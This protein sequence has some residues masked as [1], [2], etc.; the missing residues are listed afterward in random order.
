MDP[1]FF[2]GKRVTVTGGRGFLGRF[3]C[4]QLTASGAQVSALGRRDYDL[5]EQADVRRLFAE[6]RPQVLIHLAAA[7]GGIG[8]NV[9][10]PGR[11]LYENGLM[12]LMLLDEARR[13]GVEKFVLI[14]STCSYPKEA[15]MPLREESIWEGKPVGATG[16]YGMAKR[17][18]HE[19]LATYR[20]QYGLQGVV[21]V[22][23]NLYGPEDHFDPALSHVIPGIIRRYVEAVEQ[24]AERVQNWGSG[25]PTRE[26]LHVRDAAR[27]IVLATARH[28][29]PAPVNLGTGVE[30]PIRELAEM[31]ARATGFTGEIA[32]DPT[33]PDG[34]PRRVLDVS[35]ARAFGF[36]ARVPL[37]E[38]LA[39]TV[40]WYKA[41]R[42]D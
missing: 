29:D 21:L 28:R 7:V 35:K 10:N 11:F 41:H 38:G 12:G 4:R 18:L 1:A 13:A 25:T 20:E 23:A 34:Q 39:E 6:Q 30:T 32:W 5:I 15:P 33:Q 2:A 37:A 14:S 42:P 16:P 40:A 27:A 22:P 17:L 9:A 24:G 19:A 36:E 8:A 26:F 3:V 31:V